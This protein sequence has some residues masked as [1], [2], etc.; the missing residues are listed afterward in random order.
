MYLF[1]QWVFMSIFYVTD[2]VLGAEK[3]QKMKQTKI[4]SFLEYALQLCR[5]TTKKV[6]KY[7]LF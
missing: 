6:S 1:I 4:C 2:N 7:T 3:Q 5:Q